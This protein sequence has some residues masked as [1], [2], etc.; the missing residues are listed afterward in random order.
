[1]S[2]GC[3]SRCLSGLSDKERGQMQGTKLKARVGQVFYADMVFHSTPK[4]TGLAG[5]TEHATLQVY[6]LAAAT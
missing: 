6:L 2:T 4:E 1:M 3:M 5:S